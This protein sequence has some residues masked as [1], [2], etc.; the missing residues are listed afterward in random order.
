M[1]RRTGCE[2]ILKPIWGFPK[3]RGTFL[4]APLIRTLV[5]WA[6][7]W[8]TLILGNY[9]IHIMAASIHKGPLAWIPTSCTVIPI[10]DTICGLPHM[11]KATSPCGRCG[12]SRSPSS[13]EIQQL[14]LTVS[15]TK[16]NE[17]QNNQQDLQDR[18][19]PVSGWV[20]GQCI[21]ARLLVSMLVHC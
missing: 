9:H 6:L 15:L 1:G 18:G 17:K 8:G 11:N 20:V 3:I 19:R 7:Y 14:Q 5:Y 21:R 12:N 2:G 13:W 16:C 4:G 10:L